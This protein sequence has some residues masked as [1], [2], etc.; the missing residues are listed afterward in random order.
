MKLK[1]ILFVILIIL[2]STELFAI[3]ILPANSLVISKNTT[4]KYYMLTEEEM[5]LYTDKVNKL[6]KEE[7]KVVLLR[8]KIKLLESNQELLNSFVKVLLSERETYLGIID[9]LN[10]N[11]KKST[12]IKKRSRVNLI[13][14]NLIGI[15]GLL[16]IFKVF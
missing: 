7:E 8:E 6:E 11:L 4:E 14:K 3:K 1:L 13:T 9:E 5:L 10:K 2:L 15:V 16:K 12:E